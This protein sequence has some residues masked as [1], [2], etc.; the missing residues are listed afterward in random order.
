VKFYAAIISCELPLHR[1][2]SEAVKFKEAPLPFSISGNSIPEEISAV[3]WRPFLGKVIYMDN[4][5]TL[6]VTP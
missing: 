2:F 6:A 1:L 3:L 5:E 4:A